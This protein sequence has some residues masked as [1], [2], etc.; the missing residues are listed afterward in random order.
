MMDY[1]DVTRSPEYDRNFWNALRRKDYNPEL[2]ARGKVKGVDTYNLPDSDRRKFAGYLKNESLF[3]RIGTVINLGVGDH[4][5]LAKDCEDIADWIDEGE[6]IPIYEGIRDFTVNGI[7]SH[8]LASLVKF[9]EEFV[10]DASFDFNDYL[11]RRFARVMGRAE[12]KAFISGVGVKQPHGLLKPEVGAETGVTTDG[13][14]YD[15]IIRL[16]FALEPEYRDHAM[17]IMNDET[18]L[19]LRTLKSNDG[20]Y[21]W[22]HADSTILGKPVII[23]NFMPSAESGCL[24]VLFG[25]FRYYWVICRRPVSLRALYEQFAVYDQIGYLGIEF[26]DGRLIR[27]K[28]VKALQI[29]ASESEG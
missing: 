8:K 5:I 10:R 19:H 18:A 17:W 25:D 7:D 16:F 13:I 26:L 14:T 20:D 1:M 23:S 15:D 29:I 27:R 6:A 11:L 2:L 22:N 3:R 28:A 9:D 21:I 24:P 12:E 4:K